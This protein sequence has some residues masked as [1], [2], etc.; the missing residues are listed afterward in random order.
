MKKLNSKINQPEKDLIF[1]RESNFNLLNFY[2]G[3]KMNKKNFTLIELLVV[4]AIIAILASMLLPTLNKARDTAKK[5][6]CLNN[7]KQF[8]LAWAVYADNNDGEMMP[9]WAK[10]GNNS[11]VWYENV[12]YF[13]LLKLGRK[14]I[15]VVAPTWSDNG[16]MVKQL[17]CPS[18][19]PHR[20]C[21]NRFAPTYADYAYNFF[22]NNNV[23]GAS[24]ANM[25]SILSKMGQIKNPSRAIVIGDNW[26]YTQKT[27]NNT[28]MFF[29]G[30]GVNNKGYDIG[31][32][33]AHRSGMNKAFTDGH[34]A[35]EN[36]MELDTTYGYITTWDRRT[37][38]KVRN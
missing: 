35:A 5:I 22:I 4:I 28:S 13:D 10:D 19:V 32:E 23:N 12:I 27:G 38:K 37:F 1:L 16:Y 20:A 29:I 15:K 7:M 26:S 30:D 9:S 14:K 6:S 17:L 24:Y 25:V 2:N 11:I 33:A 8:G 21:W 3:E 31:L 36:F 18:A 34:A